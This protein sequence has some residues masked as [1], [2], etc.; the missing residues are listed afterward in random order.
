MHTSIVEESK[1]L[2]KQILQSK[3]QTSNMVFLAQWP[4]LHLQYSTH[5]SLERGPQYYIKDIL[6]ED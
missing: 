3:Q 1:K 5:I 6:K 4:P 2:V